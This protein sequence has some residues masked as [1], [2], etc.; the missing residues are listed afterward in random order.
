MAM[1]ALTAI[2]KTARPSVLNVKSGWKYQA[3]AICLPE[4]VVLSEDALWDKIWAH[5]LKEI[6]VGGLALE[7]LKCGTSSVVSG[8]VKLLV[9]LC[10]M[11]IAEEAV[12]EACDSDPMGGE[13]M[14]PMST[15]YLVIKW[16]PF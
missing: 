7:A 10:G 13:Y 3:H 6:D 5:A 9:A 16:I 2:M 1:V 4:G 15:L 8:A 14:I 11:P 12:C